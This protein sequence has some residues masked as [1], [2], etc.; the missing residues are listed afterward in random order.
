MLGDASSLT[1]HIQRI[2]GAHDFEPIVTHRCAQLATVKSFTAMGLGISI[3]PQSARA[4]YDPEGLVYRRFSGKPLVREI[5]LVR[6]RRHF[7]SKGARA[8]AEAARAA[9]AVCHCSSPSQK[10]LKVTM[11]RVS[12]MPP[13]VCTTPVTNR[14]GSSSGGT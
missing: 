6:H 2:G 13:I 5:M 8:F 3:L 1:A 11:V 7:L 9:I 10:A 12:R 14:P 4:A